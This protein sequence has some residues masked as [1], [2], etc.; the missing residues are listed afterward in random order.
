MMR[1]LSRLDDEVDLDS[2]KMIEIQT[3]LVEFIEAFLM[4]KNAP[5]KTLTN[6]CKNY[7]LF[8]IKECKRHYFCGAKNS[9]TGLRVVAIDNKENKKL[10]SID[11]IYYEIIIYILYDIS[12]IENEY[13]YRYIEGFF[14]ALHALRPAYCRLFGCFAKNHPLMRGYRVNQ[15]ESY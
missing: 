13:P 6:S 15:P 12:D 8:C 2:P 7:I 14:G 4:P 10:S 9:L 11:R 3:I 5:P 1:D